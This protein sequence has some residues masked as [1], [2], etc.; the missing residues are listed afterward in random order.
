MSQNPPKALFIGRFQPF[1]KGHLFVVRK[2]A[3]QDYLPV[4]VMG[5]AYQSRTEDN[6]FSAG[7]RFEM[8][9]R[10]LE[11]ENIGHHIIPVPDINRYGVWVSH[12]VDLVPPFEAVFVN[13]PIIQELFREKGYTVVETG[14]FEREEYSGTEVRQRMK[15]GEN[16]EELVPEQVVEVFREFGLEKRF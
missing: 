6:P 10:S 1:H 5:S 14:L 16:W 15:A 13:S 9:S 3:L 12:V 2:M 8:I 7:E 11:A 4:L